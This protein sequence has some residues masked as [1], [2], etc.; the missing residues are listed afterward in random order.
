MKTWIEPLELLKLAIVQQNGD[1]FSARKAIIDHLRLFPD[2]AKA[3]EYFYPTEKKVCIS[4]PSKQFWV[5]YRDCFEE[6]WTCDFYSQDPAYTPTAYAIYVLFCRPAFANAGIIPPE[7]PDGLDCLD[8]PV[9]KP[10]NQTY[11]AKGG[12]PSKSHIEAAA[13]VATKLGALERDEFARETGE[14]VSLLLTDA[15][16]QLG[17]GGAVDRQF[18]LAVLR[19]ARRARSL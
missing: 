3:T 13:F 15:Y 7:R 16:K 9:Y 12:R 1:E 17:E 5:K 8:R 19:G 14:T 18:A 6:P 4:S 2:V 11:A 10:T